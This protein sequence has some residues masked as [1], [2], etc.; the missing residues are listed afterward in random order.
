[1]KSKIQDTLTFL[2]SIKGRYIIV[3]TETTGLEPKDNNIIEIAAI[4]ILNCK[5]TGNEFHTFMNP[6]F[7]IE[8]SAEEKHKMKQNFYEEYYKNVYK[9]DKENLFNFIHFIGNSLIFAHNAIFDMKFINNELNYYNLPTIPRKRFRCSMK[10][11]K[12]IVKPHTIKKSYALDYCCEFFKLNAPIENFHSAI[13]DAFM[14]ARL[15]CCLFKYNLNLKER[16]Q[17]KFIS[18]GL[19]GKNNF[20]K[21]NVSDNNFNNES[22]NFN[23]Q[24]VISGSL[25]ERTKNSTDNA[26]LN[27]NFDD[28]EKDN[29]KKNAQEKK[30]IQNDNENIIQKEDEPIS[31]NDAEIDLFL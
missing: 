31:I 27:S 12:L 10:L 19:N 3:D 26:N 22:N 7:V 13:F 1:M 25:S 5:L 4:E 18:N 23:T 14:T 29:L 28:E 15:V 6:R 17:V 9:S 20:N 8:K 30:V 21:E 2:P 24:S 16:E 11:F